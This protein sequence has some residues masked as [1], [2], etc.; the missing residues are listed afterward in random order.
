[1]IGAG[2][3]KAA[4]NQSPERKLGVG[5]TI[6]WLL[7][8]AAIATLAVIAHTRIIQ[9]AMTPGPDGT[10]GEVYGPVSYFRWPFYTLA[11]TLTTAALVAALISALRA[12]KDIAPG[13]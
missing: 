9:P 13:H 8:A 11:G 12:R 10:Y 2:L 4:P 1:L 5:W 7:L 6:A 3:N